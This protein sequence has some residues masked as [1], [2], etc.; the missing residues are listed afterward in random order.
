MA[1]IKLVFF[2]D[3]EC[4]DHELEVF[5]NTKNKIYISISIPGYEPSFTALDKETAIKLSKVLKT[6]IS[7]L[8]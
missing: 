1:K 8:D 5:A 2:G 4:S 6:E 3:E 7:K